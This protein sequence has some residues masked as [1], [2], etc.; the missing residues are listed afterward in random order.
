MSVIYDASAI[1]P[2]R[3]TGQKTYIG[4]GGLW[5]PMNISYLSVD[6]GDEGIR[7]SVSPLAIVFHFMCGMATEVFCRSF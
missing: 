4:F 1:H 7:D 5:W 2:I 3:V 6:I